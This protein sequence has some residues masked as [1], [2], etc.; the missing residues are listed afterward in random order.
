MAN[1]FEESIFTECP[2]V[3]ALRK[4]LLELGAYAARMTG[5]GP[6]VFGLF[7]KRAEA[8]RA[9]EQLREEKILSYFAYIV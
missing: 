1:V 6:T 4:K 5:A 9:L 7:E 2:E 3:E 8:T